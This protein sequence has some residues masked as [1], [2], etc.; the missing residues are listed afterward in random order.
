[1]TNGRDATHPGAGDPPADGGPGNGGGQA[2][3]GRA[4]LKHRVRTI[5]DG[6]VELTDEVLQE[7]VVGAVVDGMAYCQTADER[8]LGPS[9]RW[10]LSRNAERMTLLADDDVAGD[11]ARRADLVDFDITVWSAAGPAVEPAVARSA[12]TPPELPLSHRRYASL[13]SEAGARAID[14]HGMLVAEV[15]GLEVARV[16]DVDEP[17]I[18]PD[19]SNASL[20]NGSSTGAELAVGVGQADR[21]LQDYIHGHLDDDANL[22]RAIAAVVQH[23]KP[24]SAVHPLSRVARQR[25]LRSILLDDPS[26]VGLDRLDPII[27]LRPRTTVLGDEPSAAAGSGAIVVCSV[28]VD[29]DLL[30]E[31]ADYR[32]RDDPH[33]ELIVV[34]PERD[35][36]LVAGRMA[37]LIPALRMVSVP[38][39]WTTD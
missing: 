27:P 1:M 3:L 34:V 24:G 32:N 21:E 12:L 39:P 7:S 16:V 19:G 23:R 13:I 15:A 35:R 28:G 18:A 4:M 20:T 9:L 38:E 37:E 29:L 22:R 6:A 25:W 5:T 14:D 36:S 11:I 26:L 33:A 30:P 31:A 17:S 8:G 2:A 10:A